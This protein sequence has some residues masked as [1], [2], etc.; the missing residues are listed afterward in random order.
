VILEIEVP[1]WI[2]RL[3]SNTGGEIRFVPGYGLEELLAA[4][5]SLIKRILP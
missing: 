5:P 2:V 3:V 1:E 4:W